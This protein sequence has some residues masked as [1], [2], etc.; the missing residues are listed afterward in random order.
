[1]DKWTY[2]QLYRCAVGGNGK[3]REYWKRCGIDTHTKID[4]KYSSMTATEYKRKL[5]VY[6]RHNSIG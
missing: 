5:E 1:M 3:A 6:H 2:R 4:V